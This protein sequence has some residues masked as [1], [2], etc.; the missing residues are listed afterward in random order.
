MIRTFLICS[1]LL[2]VMCCQ[3]NNNAMSISSR[4]IVADYINTKINRIGKLPYTL[5]ND[6]LFIAELSTTIY[7]AE[8]C[9]D[10]GTYY[11]FLDNIDHTVYQHYE[12]DWGY[13]WDT[14]DFELVLSVLES[15]NQ[16]DIISSRYDNI[17]YFL[18]NANDSCTSVITRKSIK[19]ILEYTLDSP[20]I[21]WIQNESQ[22][23]SHLDSCNDELIKSNHKALIS[24][25]KDKWKNPMIFIY[26]EYGSLYYFEVFCSETL[27]RVSPW[28]M[29]NTIVPDT[30]DNNKWS[31][32]ES[33]IREVGSYYIKHVPLICGV[34][35]YCRTDPVFQLMQND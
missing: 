35:A 26:N 7:K 19:K 11:L 33:L 20:S 8:C 13:Y 32:E 3:R 1:F 9:P 2:T 15:N 27:E 31:G 22:L 6:S 23:K 17:Q 12:S 16:L 18:N 28:A 5:Q 24:V 14:Y 21:E 34:T 10:A 30:S 29:H 25:L 4:A